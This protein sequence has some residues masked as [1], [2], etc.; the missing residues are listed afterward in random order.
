[1]TLRDGLEM[2]GGEDLLTK[3]STEALGQAIA[4][5]RIPERGSFANSKKERG[6]ATPLGA[7][8]EP[9]AQDELFE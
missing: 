2:W 8:T 1:M 3:E 7:L 5:T 6:E 4:S 9:H